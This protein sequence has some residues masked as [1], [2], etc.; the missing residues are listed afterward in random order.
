[1]SINIQRKEAG[2][3]G[4]RTIKFQAVTESVLASQRTMSEGDD[5][6]QK[7]ITEIRLCVNINDEGEQ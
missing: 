2:D 5:V 7:V 6:V 1:M 3:S 4:W